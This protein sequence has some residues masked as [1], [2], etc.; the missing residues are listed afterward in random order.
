[1][2]YLFDLLKQFAELH[3][4]IVGIQFYSY[5]LQRDADNTSIKLNH[6]LSYIMENKNMNALQQQYYNMPSELHKKFL[7]GSYQ[8]RGTAEDNDKN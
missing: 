6:E 2:E 3:P 1:M 4:S 8:Y 7:D 5:Y